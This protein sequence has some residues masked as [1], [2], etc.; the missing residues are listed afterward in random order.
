MPGEP[1]R[2]PGGI[3]EGDRRDGGRI[4]LRSPPPVPGVPPAGVPALPVPGPSAIMPDA[5][6]ILKNPD[7]PAPRAPGRP[8]ECSMPCASPALPGRASDSPLD[9]RARFPGPFPAPRP[10]RVAAGEGGARV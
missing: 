8:M 4:P 6:P 1:G 2:F 10:P 3:P 7:Y 5:A 9:R